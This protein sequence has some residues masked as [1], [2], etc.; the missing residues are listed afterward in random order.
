HI[1][2]QVYCQGI[3]GI[4]EKRKVKV[5]LIRL[6]ESVTLHVSD[7]PDNGHPRLFRGWTTSFHSQ[8]QWISIRD[9]AFRKCFVNYNNPRCL[10]IVCVGEEPATF[11][12][13]LERPKVISR[14]HANLRDREIVVSYSVTFNSKASCVMRNYEGDRVTA[15]NRGIPHA[16]NRAHSL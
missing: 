9:V 2:P 10:P 1:G 3:R 12:R 6:I 7:N 13:C 16:R 14:D 8:S 11:Q 5:R 4:L 15:A